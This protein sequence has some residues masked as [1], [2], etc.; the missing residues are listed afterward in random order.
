[1]ATTEPSKSEK[2]HKK[3]VRDD[4][5]EDG[6]RKHKRS[7]SESI[8][9]GD[10]AQ[11]EVATEKSHK[12]SKKR[13]RDAKDQPTGADS[14]AVTKE[15]KEKK[16]KSKTKFITPE[17][18]VD[19][20]DESPEATQ[21]IPDAEEAEKHSQNEPKK[22]KK[23]KKEKK[24]K[25]EKKRR[26]R[27]L[28]Q[29]GEGEPEATT[30]KPKKKDKHKKK[31]HDADP[32]LQPTAAA[33]AASAKASTTEQHH[34]AK[35][36][37]VTQIVSL[38]VPFFP[39]GFSN[40]PSELASEVLD[41]MLN[42]F[43]PSLRGMLL[44]YRKATLSD[45]PIRANPKSQ[46]AHDR[47][48]MLYAV[49]ECA[50]GFGWLTA[51]MDIFR[52]SRGAAM[53]GKL[54][55]QSEGHI[56]LVCWDKFNA[57]IESSR[58]PP[59]WQWVDTSQ[60]MADP[61]GGSA[62]ELDEG[63]GAEDALDGQGLEQLH[64]VGYWTD[65]S[66]MRVTGKLNFRIKNFQ[67]FAGDHQYLSIEGTMLDEAAEREL[68]RTEREAERTR[69]ARQ[70]PSGLLRPMLRRVP[71]FSMTTIGDDDQEEEVLAPVVPGTPVAVDPME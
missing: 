10:L 35:M 36:P 1:M 16:H 49:D 57:S 14:T 3:R 7:K 11:N 40:S 68:I 58:L 23:D 17:K 43:S 5:A 52:P 18:V 67:L 31:H 37:F 62:M 63:Q 28:A 42:T 39:Q 53:E 66:G 65:A 30:E 2:K 13:D 61:N 26:D 9:A 32:D 15:K 56:G 29:D 48:V 27:D 20:D 33:T 46:E 19:S 70:N 55:I 22:H 4:E 51:E 38:Y 45:S 21:P 41:P 8:A 44:A 12:K 24:G 59:G 69:R 54:A 6:A 47:E 60:E 34:K 25:K 71:D 64:S 50:A